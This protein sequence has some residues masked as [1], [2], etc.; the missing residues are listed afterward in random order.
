MGDVVYIFSD[1]HRDLV[2]HLERSGVEVMDE[3]VFPPYQ[4]DVY[5]PAFHV[6]IEADGPQH[7]ERRDE[8]RDKMLLETYHL[9]VFRVTPEELA[10][11]DATFERLVEFFDEH[12][13]SRWWRYAKCEVKV[14][15][16]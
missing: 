1:L 9:P 5:V 3:V 16:L 11:W 4:V 2:R 14:P 13:E 7:S 12:A 10:D 8:K 15:W 6:A